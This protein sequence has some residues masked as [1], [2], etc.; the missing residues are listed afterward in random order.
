MYKSRFFGLITGVIAASI[1]VIAATDVALS[2]VLD[3]VTKAGTLRVA[4]VTDYPPFGSINPQMKPE[5]YDIETAELL[6]RHL[7]VKAEL[8]PVA[9]ANKIPFIQVQKADVL[10]NIGHN[11]ERAKVVDFSEPYAP[12][13]I[14][15]FGPA[16]IKVSQIDDVA[17]KSVAVTRGS[18]EELVLT[19]IAPPGTDIKRYEDNATTISAYLSGQ[20]QLVAIGNIVAATLRDKPTMRPPEE[21]LLLLNSPVRAAVLKGEQRLLDKVNEAIAALKKDGTLGAMSTKWLK[22]PLP[23]GM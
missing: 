4:I 15:V 6:A 10:L 2:D 5:G 23:S 20:T 14:G 8:V 16:E 11:A 12:Y 9:S 21:K 17:G 19:K 1:P 3:D 13:Y 7:G 18:F 22:Q